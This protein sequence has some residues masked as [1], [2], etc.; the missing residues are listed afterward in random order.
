MK[1]LHVVRPRCFAQVEA[2]V[3]HLQTAGVNRLIVQPSWV[4]MCGSDIPFFTG[5]KRHKSYPLPV[6]API[7]ECFGKVIESSSDLFKPGDQV[8]AIPES[9]QGLSEFF[10]ARETKA[11]KIVFARL[12]WTMIL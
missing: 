8:V 6:A 12:A 4:S 9:D 7:H 10:V 11:V 5:S 2:D 1:A 3:P